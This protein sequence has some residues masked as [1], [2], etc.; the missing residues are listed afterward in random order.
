MHCFPSR[1]RWFFVDE[2]ELSAPP[3]V[4]LHGVPSQAYSYRKVLPILAEAGYRAIAP[5]WLGE[6]PLTRILFF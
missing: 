5:D 4:L 2:G 1:C 6:G 3:V